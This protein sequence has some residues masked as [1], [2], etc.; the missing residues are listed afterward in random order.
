MSC[1]LIL[2]LPGELNA[3]ITDRGNGVLQCE[4]KQDSSSAVVS[5]C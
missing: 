5:P 4:R 3:V 2:V 1:D